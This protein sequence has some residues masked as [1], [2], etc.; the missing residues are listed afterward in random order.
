M[1]IFLFCMIVATNYNKQQNR[2]C[3]NGDYMSNTRAQIHATRHRNF[4][5]S[6]CLIFVLHCTWFPFFFVFAPFAFCLH[7]SISLCTFLKTNRM[8]TFVCTFH[9]VA[10]LGSW[11]KF[12]VSFA[13]HKLRIEN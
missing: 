7:I 10:N 9:F 5:H 8:H 1:K 6:L 2:Q 12:D 3:M 13:L 4:Y 11:S